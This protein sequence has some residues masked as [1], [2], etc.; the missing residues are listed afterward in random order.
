MRTLFTFFLL[1]YT[2]LSYAQFGPYSQPVKPAEWVAPFDLNLYRESLINKQQQAERQQQMIQEYLRQ[3]EENERYEAEQQRGKFYRQR[4]QVISWYNSQSN[5]TIPTNGWH[6]VWM[7]NETDFNY[8]QRQVYVDGGTITK[9]YKNEETSFIV[10]YSSRI[11]NGYARVTI[12]SSGESSNDA[13]ITEIY[14]L[15]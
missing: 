6:K 10:D 2:F 15:E 4:N 7:F 14:F 12:H 8:G 11:N 13:S 1:T 9:Y 5:R 3:K